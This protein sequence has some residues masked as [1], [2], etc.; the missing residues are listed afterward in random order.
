MLQVT[1]HHCGKEFEARRCSRKFCS[2]HCKSIAGIKKKAAQMKPRK[3]VQCG[4]TYQ[5]QWLSQVKFCSRSCETTYSHAHLWTP[6]DVICQDC[7][8]TFKC[9]RRDRKR[10]DE[11]RRKFNSREVMRLRAQKNAEVRVGQGSGS[12][13]FPVDVPQLMRRRRDHSIRRKIFSGATG[14]CDMCGWA[15]L[16]PLLQLHHRNQNPGDNDPEN[17]KLLCP[18]C[19]AWV[20]YDIKQCVRRGEQYTQALCVRMFSKTKAEVKSR[21]EAGTPGAPGQSEPKA[22]GN[23][24]QG[25]RIVA[26]EEPPISH[27]EAATT[28]PSVENIC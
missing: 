26:G 18:T 21:N 4:K 20:H 12:G 6:K 16:Q 22:G 13:Q 25:Q 1:C 2:D 7:G 11:C 3:C 19:H 14:S 8:Q 23:I 5:P 15:L 17:L 24:G 28:E 9:V 27:H 10:C